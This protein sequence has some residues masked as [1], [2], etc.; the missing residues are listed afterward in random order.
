VIALVIAA[1]GAVAIVAGIAVLTRS[2]GF[3]TG[4]LLAGAREVSIERA[5][6][7]AT[8]DESQYVRVHGRI[9]SDEE[10]PDEN[11]RP[12]VYRRK[13]IELQDANGNWRDEASETEAVPFGVESRTSYIAVDGSRLAAGLVVI[14]RVAEGVAADLPAEFAA[15]VEPSARARLLVEQ[16]SAVEH[17]WVAG[18]PRIEPGPGTQAV[19]SAGLGRPLIV[20]TL[21][22]ADAMR[23]L[24]EGRRLSMAISAGL[25]VLGA[26]LVVAALVAA[27]AGAA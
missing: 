10:F 11:D 6:E 16:I 19:I 7:L 9:S 27:I 24:G 12:L 5:L 3:R 20:T 25:V 4:R 26:I 23:V 18:V 21:E 13:R 15:D 14:P 22:I 17:A 2:P 1:L 8:A